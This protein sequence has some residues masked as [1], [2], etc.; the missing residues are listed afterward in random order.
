MQEKKNTSNLDDIYLLKSVSLEEIFDGNEIDEILKE[1]CF[2]SDDSEEEQNQEEIK[3]KVLSR[4]KK[5]AMNFD[6]STLV[7]RFITIAIDKLKDINKVVA[8]SL[9]WVKTEIQDKLVTD[10]ANSVVKNPNN[11]LSLDIDIKNI[12]GWID[13][14]SNYNPG[15]EFNTKRIATTL[16]DPSTLLSTQMQ[17]KSLIIQPTFLKKIHDSNA[18]NEFMH[19]IEEIKRTN[20]KAKKLGTTIFTE[21]MD[22]FEFEKPVIYNED[23]IESINSLQFD[24]FNYEQEVGRENVLSDMTFQ[25]FFNYDLYTIINMAAME[26]FIFHIRDGY[27]K[28]NPYHHDL[29]AADVLHTCYSIFLHSNIKEIL[30]IDYIDL[31]SFFIAAIIHDFKHPGLTNGFL[32]A[33]KNSLAIDYNGK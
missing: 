8:K 33:T 21:K 22:N 5:H 15:N 6:R 12:V 2:W 24:I 9:G 13:D 26:K 16:K 32:I 28:S 31:C 20:K 25:T 19:G 4:Y 10:G 30:M 3:Y 23:I 18:L 14:H 1:N 7:I 17:R 29:H 11:K 27:I